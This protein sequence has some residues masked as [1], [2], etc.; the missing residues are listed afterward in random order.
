MDP[1]Y[2]IKEKSYNYFNLLSISVALACKNFNVTGKFAFVHNNYAFECSVYDD[3]IS[4]TKLFVDYDSNIDDYILKILIEK[5]V[6]GIIPMTQDVKNKLIKDYKLV[7]VL[8]GEYLNDSDEQAVAYS[9]RNR[10]IF[11]NAF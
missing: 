4:G 7:E 11:D 10:T 3:E 5:R 1:I 8:V 6:L 2:N 9:A